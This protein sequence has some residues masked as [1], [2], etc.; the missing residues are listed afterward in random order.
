[1]TIKREWIN[2]SLFVCFVPP[3]ADKHATFA[4][5]RLTVLIIIRKL[6]V[7]SIYYTEGQYIMYVSLYR[8]GVNT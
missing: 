8:Y 1:M 5:K 6:V 7:V 2:R 4:F 3:P